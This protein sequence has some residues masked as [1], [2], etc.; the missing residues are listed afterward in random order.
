MDA[1][2]GRVGLY[3]MK[4]ST[5]DRILVL[6]VLLAPFSMIVLSKWRASLETSYVPMQGEY[7][8]FFDAPFEKHV[9]GWLA[10]QAISGPELI[11][12]VASDCP[13]TQA[14]RSSLQKAL[15]E[16]S[17]P[18]A[19]LTLRYIDDPQAAADADWQAVLAAIPAT[20]TLLAVDQQRLLYAGPVT[21]GNFCTTAVNRVLGLTVLEA[22]PDNPVINWFDEGCYCHLKGA[23]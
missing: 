15:A 10:R 9:A 16:A 3:T 14:T 19:R 17:R 1:S 11:L 6:L 12:I 7:R 13:C 4:D 18:E 5:Y 8:E 20:P 22:R 21:S 2:H 23:S